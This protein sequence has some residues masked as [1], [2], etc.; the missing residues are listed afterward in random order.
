MVVISPSGKLSGCCTAAKKT[1]TA[2]AQTLS[3]ATWG[4]VGEQ[5][6][7]NKT[8]LKLAQLFFHPRSVTIDK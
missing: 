5:R 1:A 4:L 3:G 6:P 7:T 8:R 2:H